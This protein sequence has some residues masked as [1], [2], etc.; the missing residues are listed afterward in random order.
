ML[1]FYDDTF[2]CD[3]EQLP[4]E[5]MAHYFLKESTAMDD[6][7][8][9]MKG[10]R[11]KNTSINSCK[12][13]I[14]SSCSSDR[15]ETSLGANCHVAIAAVKGVATIHPDIKDDG[16]F[17]KFLQ[18]YLRTNSVALS[19][20]DH[21]ELLRFIR[22]GRCVETMRQDN[23]KCLDVAKRKCQK[24]KL[25]V[26]QVVRMKMEDLEPLILSIPDLYVVHY[27]RDPR[28]IAYSRYKTGC[29]LFDKVNRS[30]VR[31][32][33]FICEKMRED[34]RQRAILEK[35]YPGV[36]THFTYERLA[37]DPESFA[38]RIYATFNRSHPK[39]W[40]AFV[41]KHMRGSGSGFNFDISV[42]N[43]TETAFKWR[44]KIP[45]DQRKKIATFCD[46][47]I[48]TLGYQL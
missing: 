40:K 45:K 47:V 6:Y 42:R 39:Q 25:R 36:F 18:D 28:A 9:C 7:V 37:A 27:T 32:A 8:R 48:N 30:I 10:N 4:P 35:K 19:F 21:E 43:A 11:S 24:D 44:N 1:N 12:S 41:A 31:E 17:A 16:E 34:V 29:L 20:S 46:D 38:R 3:Y 5:A 2:S 33:E 26:V 22:H 15:V 14:M 13:H 23:A